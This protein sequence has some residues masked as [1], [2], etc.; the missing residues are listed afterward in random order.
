M[1]VW[2]CVDVFAWAKAEI[3]WKSGTH[4]RKTGPMSLYLPSS[5]CGCCP[6][7]PFIP[8]RM[9]D[10]LPAGSSISR[11][12]GQDTHHPHKLPSPSHHPAVWC[13][14]LCTKVKAKESVKYLPSASNEGLDAVI[15]KEKL[16]ILRVFNVYICSPSQPE[17]SK[18]VVVLG[19]TCILFLEI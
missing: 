18:Y 7:K 13:I 14:M 6:Q 17:R 19:N 15:L 2:V 5:L 9:R 4:I 12:L 1:C 11:D 10:S 8:H 16:L 3:K